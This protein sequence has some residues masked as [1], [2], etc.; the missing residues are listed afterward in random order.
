MN[1]TYPLDSDA[2]KD[3]ANDTRPGG[4]H[5]GDTLLPQGLGS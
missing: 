4:S 5:Q 2:E 1:P 3:K